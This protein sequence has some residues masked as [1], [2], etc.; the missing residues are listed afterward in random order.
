MFD[1]NFYDVQ[2]N[3]ESWVSGPKRDHTDTRY[4]PAHPE[5]DPGA[6]ETYHDFLETAPLPGQEDG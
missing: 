1:A 2:T 4:G 5:L 6:V 3:E